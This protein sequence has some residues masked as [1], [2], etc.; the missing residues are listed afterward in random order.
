MQHI[1]LHSER[2]SPTFARLMWINITAVL[3]SHLHTP[4][5]I[6]TVVTLLHDIL[7]AHTQPHFQLQDECGIFHP[8]WT[9]LD[10]TA[11]KDCRYNIRPGVY[12]L[13]MGTWA[14]KSSWVWLAPIS[15]IP[16]T[17]HPFH[18]SFLGVFSWILFKKHKIKIMDT[19]FCRLW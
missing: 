15:S 16:I 9:Y 4:Q 17:P 7:A 12:H 11:L 8:V 14:A 5:A 2:I 6:Q 3:N 1:Y 10:L 19:K 18:V 13:P